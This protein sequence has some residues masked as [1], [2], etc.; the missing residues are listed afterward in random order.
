MRQ[1]D[2]FVLDDSADFDSWRPLFEDP[3]LGWFHVRDWNE[4]LNNLEAEWIVFAHKSAK[5]D[6]DF[7][8]ELAQVTDGFPMAD[9]FAPRV[10]IDDRFI[11]G[12]L[13]DGGRGFKT[14]DENAKMR[15]VAGPN[16]LIGVYS[17]RI[18]QR[19]GL[20]DTD[21]PSELQLLDY[22]LRMYHAGGKMFSVPYLVTEA[23]EPPRFNY[24][25]KNVVNPIWDIVYKNL[26]L[27]NLYKFMLHHPAT[28]VKMFKTRELDFKRDKATSLS[29]MKSKTIEEITTT[30]ND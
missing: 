7:L 20:F 24:E 15:F 27:S 3:A 10:K 28:I 21:L 2:V 11:G 30:K 1:F 8:N 12:M 5:V 23:L 14:L 6:R 18:I 25:L 17:R 19:T 26:P 4:E 13:L 16:P 22:T 9:A 29:K